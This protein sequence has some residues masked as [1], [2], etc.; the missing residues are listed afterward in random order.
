[1][2]S[3]KRRSS[4]R[5]R[6]LE[7]A[8]GTLIA[9]DFR[10]LTSEEII[11]AS[12]YEVKTV[13][14]L[15]NNRFG[16]PNLSDCCTSCGA[17]RTD[18]SNSAC[19][20]HSGHIELPVLVYHWDRISALEAILNRV[21]L[22]CY[23]FKHKGRKKELRTLSS[24]EQVASGVD[25]HQADIGA[26]PNGAR[27]PEAEENPGKCT[28]CSGPAAAVKKIFKKVGTANVPALLL[29]IDGK[30]RREDIPP[31]FQSL[32][33]KDEM[34]PQWRSKMLDPN[35]VLRILKCLP[36]ETIDKLRDE[37]LPSIPAEDYFIKS[38]PVPP[39]WMRYST[40]EFYFQDKT[41]KNLKHLLTKIK[42]IVYTRDEDKISLLTEQKVMEIQAAATQCIRANPL[43]GNVSDEDPRY[44]NVSDES[45]P[46]SGLH[47]LRSLTGKYC[48]SSAR[49]V[50]IGDPA[51]KLEEI[52]ISA[53]IAA[54]LVVLETV[55]SSNIIFLQ[56]YA[57]NNPGLKVVRGG[58]VCTA[59][60]CKKL[61][62]GDVIHRSLKDGDQVF[63]NR[64]PTFHKHALIGLKSK[65][66]RNNV[67]AVNP[68]ICPPLFADFDGDTLAL[69][70]PQSLQV[71]AEVAELVALPKQL[72]S[73]Q[74]GQSIIGLTQD[75]LLGA[76]LM[77]RKNVFLDKLD[78]DQ[79]RMW[80]PSA[81][82][83]V[84]AIVK[85]PRKSPLWTGQQLFQMT[86]PTT[87]DWESDD[88][89]LIIR[90][91]EIL[92]TS[93][94]SSAWLGKDGLMTTICRRYGPDRALEHLDIAQGIAVDW[95]SERGFSVGLCDFYMAADAVSRRKLEEET[96]CAVEEAKIS[97]LA[98]QIVSDPR[99]QVNSVSRPRCNS[100]NERVQPVTSV[101]E[102][103]QQAAI[104]A[105]QSTMKA[106]E[107]TIEEHVRENSRENS[108]LRMVEANSKGSFSK[109][110]QQGGCLGLQ[111][112]QGEF[113]Y[114]RVKSLF[115][116]AVENESRGYLT[117]SELWKSMGL[118]ESS[119][120]DGL[121][122]R[123]FFIHSLSSRKGNDGSQQRCASFFRFL[124]SYMKDI[125]VEYDNTIRSTHG[126]H[127]FQFS[128]GATAE[129]G[130][131]VGLLAGTAVI[132]PVYDQVM[133]SSPQ[134]STMLKTL[135]N[136]LFSNSFKD[137]DRCVTLKLQKLPVQPEWIALQVQDFLKP[138]TIGM[139]ASKI[140]IEYSPCSEVGG[141]KKRVPWIGCFQLRAEAMERCSLNI[142]TIVCHLRKLLPTSLDDPDAFIQGLHFFSRDVEVLCFFPITSS[143]SNYDSK[144]I[145]K[146][147]IGTM[148]GNLLQVVVKGCPR[149]I[150][151]VNVKWEDE[152]CIEVAFLS[153][154]RGVPWTHALEAC[155]SISHL[156]DWQKSTP[157]SI[158]EVHVAFGIEAAYQ[159]LLEK[160]KE[161]TKGCERIINI[162]HLILI[163]DVACHS[164]SVNGFIAGVLR[165][166]WKNIDA[167]ESG[168]EAFV[169]NLSG[170]SP[171]AFAMGKSPG[172]VFEAAAMNRE[173]DYLAGANELAFCG[174]SPS[175]GTGANI[176]LFFKEDKGPVSR[177]PDFESLVFSRRVVDD[178]VSATL[179]AKDREI[180]WARIDQ[181]SQKLH[182]ILRKS[183]TGTPV[184]AANEAV[185]LDT[186]K[187]HPMMDSKVG[188]GVRHIRV[189]NHHSFGGRC[190]HIVRLD[191]S[192][193]DFS[194]HKCLLERIKGNTVLVQRY[195]KKF[196]GGKNGRKEEVPVEIFSQKN[197][198]GLKS[199]LQPKV[200]EEEGFMDVIGK[201][202]SLKIS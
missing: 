74:G 7:E 78:M 96:L 99:F 48:G 36:Q 140:W 79:L 15:Q 69:Y 118:V 1:M 112:R 29:E 76:H 169:K 102:A 192:V 194:Y 180:V 42:S 156:V 131:P 49:A 88:G 191:G 165:K 127:I 142:D 161:F 115:P 55:T 13:R 73:S 184:S 95:I 121:D 67:F 85:S 176:E 164:G 23:S 25:A 138:V 77:T 145:H 35:Q 193:E 98:H 198:T 153:R 87:F 91:G 116:R 126:G 107:R 44:G 168:Y 93:D 148:F 70:L 160:L 22:H 20:G 150:E 123:E 175:L 18:A 172:G 181:R 61:Q 108:L 149:G 146:H 151:F 185:I 159:Y 124:M 195:K 103:T 63:V 137:I 14:A 97:S 90:Q 129:P 51:L 197:D 53:R 92:R 11:R 75:A 173:V 83:P 81:E 200:N 188:C 189:D 105:F 27:A 57:Y 186:L 155:G 132:E 110:M 39:N 30:V 167:N 117:S 52:G 5:D 100:W 171:L 94:K 104:S 64:P 163:A 50:V 58:E 109:M 46:L 28:V 130:E 26:V 136:I 86:L 122:P 89:G 202:C 8:T 62:V 147:M 174:K 56:S 201:L 158:Q 72:V 152:L 190:F 38:L 135:Q 21:C 59:R 84:P 24:L 170:C 106:F 101:N 157:L 134:A 125:R 182:D 12:V 34:T 183:L 33:L 143:V 16:L 141:Q 82:V 41:T 4:H 60:S 68:L 37:K 32:I 54:G 6:A 17:K 166:P 40:N 154:T 139:L 120:L 2:A 3:S 71:R 179:S 66:I 80:C 119:F 31:G 43:Y 45:K 199:F 10:P 111:L 133:S 196:M 178:T 65:V 113:V 19:P 144:Q 9:L 177:F 128:Y 47:F 114:H 162:E 187:Y